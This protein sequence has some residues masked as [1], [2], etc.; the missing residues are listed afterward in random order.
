MHAPD[1]QKDL[2]VYETF[3]K[4]VT[5]VLWEGRRA[6]A[7]DF[8]ITSEFNVEL[9][10]CTN[11]DDNDELNEMYGPLCWQGCDNDPSGFNKLMCV[12]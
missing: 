2:D 6:G 5:K 12:E 1:C 3:I 7:K 9:G 10:Y 4:Y 11:E 8:Y